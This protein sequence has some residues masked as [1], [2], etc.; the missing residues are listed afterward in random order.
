[1][2][3]ENTLVKCEL[4]KRLSRKLKHTPGAFRGSRNFRTR[5]SASHIKICLQDCVSLRRRFNR[6]KERE[7]YLDSELS[8]GAAAN[9]IINNSIIQ[10]RGMWQITSRRN[11]DIESG[12][13]PILKYQTYTLSC[14]RIL[15]SH[16]DSLTQTPALSVTSST[17]QSNWGETD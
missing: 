14:S 10:V 13:K 15:T 7:R 4:P 1:M 6:N 3:E 17:L 16:S 9:S 5:P 2:D 12:E 8:V 11:V